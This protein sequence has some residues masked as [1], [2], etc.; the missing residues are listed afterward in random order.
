MKSKKTSSPAAGMT[1]N[2]FLAH[3]GYASRRK[4]VELVKSGVVSVNNFK[5]TDPGFRVSSKD[6]VRVKG[7]LIQPEALV[8]I[9][10]NKPRGV[11][12]TVSDE[13]NRA[14]VLDLVS[15]PARVYPVGRLDRNT[16]GILLL[17]NDG[18][19]AQRLAHPRYSVPKTYHV[20]LHKPVSQEDIAAIKKG[21]RLSDGMVRIDAI[22]H[23]PKAPAT[24]V[25]VELHSGK[26][27]IVR[28]LFE[29]LGYFIDKLDR[30][31]YAG[32]SKRAIPIGRWR[33]L[34]KSEVEQL[35]KIAGL[36][37]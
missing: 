20:V 6:Q 14:S 25:R 10:L 31:S 36:S 15:V 24:C 2:K 18:E 16:T 30:V 7:K 21:I 33:H 12:T 4:A 11:I 23:L 9:I 35:K 3:A 22:G 26:N 34:K 1:L 29:A 17:T 27:R 8:Y 13:K 5:I 28:R 37:E 19:L 32:L